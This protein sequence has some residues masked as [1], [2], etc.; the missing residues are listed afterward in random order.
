AR[1][2]SEVCAGHLGVER[3]LVLT[4]LM[5][6]TPAELAQATDVKEWKK[7]Q[8]DLVPGR[9]AP[10]ITVIERDYPNTYAKFTALAPLLTKVGNGGKGIAWNTEEEVHKLAELN[11]TVQSEGVAKGL[12]RIETDIDA[13]EVILML[14]P[15]TNGAVAVKAWEALSKITGREHKH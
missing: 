6:D 10:A 14:A 3:D 7:G 12:P 9:T 13:A 5:H 2:F 4:P 11:Y 15:E 8:C 1:K